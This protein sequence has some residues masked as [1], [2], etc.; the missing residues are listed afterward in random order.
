MRKVLEMSKMAVAV[1]KAFVEYQ[2]L[3]RKPSDQL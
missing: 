3:H 1:I 2:I